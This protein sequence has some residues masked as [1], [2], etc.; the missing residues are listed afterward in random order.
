MEVAFQEGLKSTTSF[1]N[2]RMRD[3]RTYRFAGILDGVR[4]QNGDVVKV[5]NEG[6]VQDDNQTIRLFREQRSAWP[7]APSSEQEQV[8]ERGQP[9][10]PSSAPAV[11]RSVYVQGRMTRT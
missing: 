6:A 9:S 3:G 4:M 10:E 8:V 11:G 7:W 2:I 5:D 1:D